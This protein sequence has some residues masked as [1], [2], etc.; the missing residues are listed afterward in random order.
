[1]GTNYKDLPDVIARRLMKSIVTSDNIV[2]RAKTDYMKGNIDMHTMMA[3]V[4][5][6]ADLEKKLDEAKKIIDRMKLCL[7]ALNQSTD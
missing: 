3:V 5:D 1:M 6:N 2:A 7:A 4:Y